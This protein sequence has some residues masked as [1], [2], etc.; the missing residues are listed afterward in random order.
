MKFATTVTSLAAVAAVLLGPVTGTQAQE[1][2][3][4]KP[5]RMIVPYAPGGPGDLN[6]R[7][8]AE[9][10][11]KQL[12]QP[13]IVDNR[14]GALT[15]IGHRALS[16]ATPDGYTFGMVTVAAVVLP[17][18][19]KG[20]QVDPIKGFTP[21]SQYNWGDYAIIASPKLPARNFSELVAYAKAN[22][23][24]FNIGT[25]GG[26]LD[27]VVAL[28]GD[29]A[30]VNWSI[31]RY[32][33]VAPSRLAVLGSDI[34][35]A[36]DTTGFAREQAEGGKVK[37]L[38]VTSDRRSADSPNVPTIAESGLPGFNARFWWGFGGPP[39]MPAEAVKVLNAALRVAATSPEAQTAQKVDGIWPATGTPEEFARLI[40]DESRRWS[41]VAKKHN[42]VQDN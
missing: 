25:G 31:V 41:A 40:S 14:P 7:A 13:V 32:K 15:G 4:S 42:I 23:A 5:L 21:I 9:S 1:K 11:R 33:G 36:I 20:Y 24:R 29:S 30:G 19:M 28:L 17:A 10:L 22:P 27:L 35:A 2:Y 34:D 37:F 8:V 26:H 38:A 6:A 3:P 39:G 12:G 16:E 18:T